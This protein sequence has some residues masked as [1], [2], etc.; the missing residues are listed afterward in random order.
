MKKL[1]LSPKNCSGQQDSG[2]RFSSK[3]AKHFCALYA[4]AALRESTMLLPT[5]LS[6]KDS[7]KWLQIQDAIGIDVDHLRLTV[8]GLCH[9][10]VAIEMNV[11]VKKITGFEP[12]H[13]GQETA[14]AGVCTVGAIMN[15][16]GGRMGNEHIEPATIA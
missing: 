2:M 8:A 16:K 9:F 5:T 6:P 3:G 11:T 12:A 15:A 1:S 14:K 10:V 13:E 7:A 4:F